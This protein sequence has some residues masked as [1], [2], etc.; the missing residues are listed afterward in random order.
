MLHLVS[1]RR[2]GRLLT[3]LL[4]STAVIFS[5]FVTAP[6]THAASATNL[7][8]NGNIP[9]GTTIV[10]KKN[11]PLSPTLC[12]TLQRHLV[13][14]GVKTD[15]NCFWII[16]STTTYMTGAASHPQ[17]VTGG[18]GGG[19]PDTVVANHTLNGTLNFFGYNDLAVSMQETFA[20]DGTCSPP[21]VSNQR[22]SIQYTIFPI[23]SATVS[24]CGAWLHNNIDTV[25]EGDFYATYA[26]GAG[27]YTHYLESIGNGNTGE[28][29]DT[30]N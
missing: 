10:E 6:I 20:W 4:L 14:R 12:A 1:S 30:V 19:C 21:S 5:F 24:Y 29:S 9:S 22:C 16:T 7:S 18:G 28:I 26:L 2:A 8:K 11:I 27:S 3:L 15:E 23:A 13:Q 17:A 25:A